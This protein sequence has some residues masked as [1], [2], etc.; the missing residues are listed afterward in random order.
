MRAFGIPACYAN[1]PANARDCDVVGI[2]TILL[3]YLIAASL[4]FLAFW[5]KDRTTSWCRGIS[6]GLGLPLLFTLE[7]GNLILA[8]LIFFV[9]AYGDIVRSGLL[10][11]LAVGAT[12]NFKPYLVLTTLAYLF[13]RQWR[14]L[15]L[16]AVATILI[17]VLSLGA[18]GSGTPQQL[19]ANTQ[20]WVQL[21]GGLVWEQ[22]YY[23]T[24]Y[25]PFLDFNTYRFPSRDFV[26][27]AIL[28]PFFAAIPIVIWTSRVLAAVTFVGAWLQPGAVSRNRLMLLFLSAYMVGASPGGYTITFLIILLF[29]ER[30]RGVGP[31]VAI[32]CGYLLSM[33]FDW[34]LGTFITMNETSW[35]SHRTVEAP[36]G[37]S[38]GMLVRPGL[39][40]VIFWALALDSLADIVRAHR[41]NPPMPALARSF[42]RA[43]A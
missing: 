6:F 19:L 30:F 33:H 37:L 1:N 3:C 7:R 35:L 41:K 16:A 21:V 17:Y 39:I 23:S 29:F 20:A 11:A 31:I 27:S 42:V 10:R 4:A 36:F 13:K 14:R 9:L 32:S 25:A 2:S 8:T 26:T 18:F 15:E 43:A 24:S 22:S 40:V 5:K 34:V 38:V 28:D 12:I